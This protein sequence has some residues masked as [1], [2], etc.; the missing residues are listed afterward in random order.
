MSPPR[1]SSGA[2]R[3]LARF[4]PDSRR[5]RRWVAGLAAVGS[6]LSFYAAF[7]VAS[8]VESGTV[9]NLLIVLFAVL[10]LTLPAIASATLLAPDSGLTRTKTAGRGTT[11][12][13]ATST[14]A[15]R[16]EDAVETLKRRYAAGEIDREEFDRRLDDLVEVSGDT[17]CETADAVETR[18]ARDPELDRAGR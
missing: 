18:A 13:R 12:T 1:D 3:A 15:T 6:A 9:Y 7:A 17:G 14:G 2:L 11:R 16:G 10:T 4:T 5:W 8:G